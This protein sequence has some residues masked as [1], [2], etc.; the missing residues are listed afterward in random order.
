MS[1]GLNPKILTYW[2]WLEEIHGVMMI[3]DLLQFIKTT[4]Q[5]NIPIGAIFISS[6]RNKGG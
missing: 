1:Q 5:K 3:T 2:W 6:Y 4:F